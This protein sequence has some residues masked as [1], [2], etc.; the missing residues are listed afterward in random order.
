MSQ[1]YSEKLK[2]P[3]W[4]K[5]RLETLQ[6]DFWTCRKC[7]DTETTLHVH[8]T[9][10]SPGVEPWEYRREQLVTLCETCHKIEP[11]AFRIYADT[12][13]ESLQLAGWISTEVLELATWVGLVD[14]GELDAL[15]YEHLHP[16]KAL[17]GTEVERQPVGASVAH[18]TPDPRPEQSPLHLDD[19]PRAS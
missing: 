14:A 7:G 19:A 16:K 17:S 9:L 8:H 15:I 10:Y 12:L 13:V 3:R 4:Q 5:V 2:D 6:R 18:N 1:S 11:E